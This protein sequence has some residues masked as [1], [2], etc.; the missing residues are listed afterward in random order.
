MRGKSLKKFIFLFISLTLILFYLKAFSSDD[1]G[2]SNHKIVN[3]EEVYQPN[4]GDNKHK[5][6]HSNETKNMTYPAN[7]HVNP[8]KKSESKDITYP[9]KGHENQSKKT[10]HKDENTHKAAEDTH[11]HNDGHEQK[12]DS[13]ST[14][15]THYEDEGYEIFKPKG[16]IWFAAVFVVLLI[17]IFVFT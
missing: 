1:K 11:G 2:S 12:K 8:S 10:E 9:A 3:G 17:V 13:H 14:K 16:L 7:G 15:L 6:E 4:T 5:K